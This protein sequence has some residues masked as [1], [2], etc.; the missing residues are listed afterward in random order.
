VRQ[1]GEQGAA[2][3]S[4][5]LMDSVGTRLSRIHVPAEIFFVEALPENATGK[6]DRKALRQMACAS[7]TSPAA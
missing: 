6:V 4:D 7:R 1:T 3:R 2:L 5:D